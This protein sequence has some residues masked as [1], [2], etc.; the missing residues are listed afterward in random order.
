MLTTTFF[1]A[2]PAE[3]S[4]KAGLQDEQIWGLDYT[5]FQ[6]KIWNFTI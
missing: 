4:A 1:N 5:I 3:A 6:I 2:L